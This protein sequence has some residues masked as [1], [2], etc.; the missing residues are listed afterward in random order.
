MEAQFAPPPLLC[1]SP[2]ALLPRA[3]IRA[4]QA[5]GKICLSQDTGTMEAPAQLLCLLLLWLPGICGEIVMTPT[6]VSLSLSPG[7]RATISCRASQSRSNNYLA[8][9]QQKP[10]QA[11]RLL[12]YDASSRPMAAGLAQTL[13]ISSLEPEDA[14][15]YYCHQYNNFPPTVMP[16]QKPPREQ[17]CE[18]GQPQ[19]LLLVS[20]Q[21]RLFSDQCHFQRPQGTMEAPAQLLCL[22]LLWLP[23]TSGAIVMTQSPASLS[24]SPGERATI[25]CRAS[26]S[27]RIYLNWY[28]QKPGQ[29]PRMLIYGATNRPSG[30]P[31]RFSG[32][33]SGTDFTLTISSLQ[34]EDAA[35]YYCQQG[36][37]SPPTICLSQDT[38]TM[39][40]PAQLLCLLLLWL[41]GTSGAIVLTQTPASLSLSPGERA[42]IS[43]RASQSVNG[44]LA[45]YQQKPGQAPRL[46]IYAASSRPSD[47]PARFSGSGSGTDFTLTISSLEPE[48]A[49]TYYCHHYYYSN[50]PP[51]MCEAGQPQ[52]LLLVPQQ[53][54]LF[55]RRCRAAQSPYQGWADPGQDLP[56]PEHRDMEAPALL[57]CLLLLWLPG[58]RCATQ[59]T[60]SPASM[61]ASPGDRVTISCRASQS[62]SNALAWYQQKPGQAPR[63]L[64]YWA[65]SRPSN[66]PSR[67][68]GSGSGTDFTLTISSLEPEDAATYYCQ[69]HYSTPPTVIQA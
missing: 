67:F 47:I 35:T 49:A 7:E 16:E 32:S 4:G 30:I 31:A 13:T 36:D 3:H 26:Q 50:L 54:R 27:V 23:G 57:L 28:Q 41:P 55:S 29:A 65:S 34:P 62:V 51:T 46:L 58:A 17:M 68:S 61:S 10:G 6:P 18:A 8:W 33:G 69:Q 39:E 12:I 56:Q 45:W 40:A 48:D 9:Y 63:M 66:I 64:I 38:G 20:W 42:T 15:T 43:C 14:A 24:L 44:Y 60:Q 53:L 19:L 52:L 11:P 1:M 22:L 25:S 2:A 5:L 21:L 59:M 37:S